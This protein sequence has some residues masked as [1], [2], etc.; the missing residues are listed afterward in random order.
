MRTLITG[1]AL[2]ESPRWHCDRLWFVDMGT[3]RVAAAGLDGAYELIAEVPAMPMGIGWLPDGRMLIVSSRDGRLL[4]RDRNGQLSAYADLSTL[5]DHPWSDMA[6]D[7]RGNAYVGCIG[8]DF[9]AGEP[10]PGILALVTPDGGVRTVAEDLMFP[11]GIAVTPDNSTL[12]V[13]ESYAHRL[14]AFVIAPDGSLRDRRVW[15]ELPGDFPD[16]ICLDAEG[17]VW[18][19]SVPGQHCVRVREGG[20]VLR[21]IELGGGGFACVLGG[22]GRR[23]L[24]VM[25]ADWGGPQSMTAGQRTGRAVAIEVEVPGAGWP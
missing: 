2:G 13:A 9:P 17:A 12:I 20:E 1:L 4:Q 18:Y 24:F 23:T 16:G 21:T 19:A 8:F 3:H 11:N 14:T 6:V 5:D 7:G 10:R 25:V 22:E 15:A